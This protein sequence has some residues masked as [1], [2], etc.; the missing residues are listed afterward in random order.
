MAS[1]IVLKKSSVASKVPLAA[2]L[3]YGEVALNYQDG[4]LYYKKANNT[5]DAFTATLTSSAVTTAL[6][7]TPLSTGG[8]TITGDITATMN[9]AVHGFS[10]LP[11]GYV[12]SNPQNFRF[13]QDVLRYV[14][15]RVEAVIT[16]S[17]FTLG[18]V[19]VLFSQYASF[20]N[21]NGKADGSY[22]QIEGF[23][24]NNSANGYWW[25][26]IFTHAGSYSGANITME[27]K[28][29]GSAS[30]QTLYTGTFGSYKI[31]NIGSIGGSLTGVRW[32]FTGQ[33]TVNTYVR[34]LGV[35]GRNSDAY[36]WNIMKGGDTMFGDLTFA[37][38]Y[39]VRAPIFYDSA[40]PSFY[41]DPN[42]T[43]VL[44]G[45][46]LA[47]TATFN[48]SAVFNNT[49]THSGLTLTDGTNV[50][51]VKTITKSITL[52]TDWQDTGIKSTDLATGTYIVQL[53]ANDSGSGGTNNNEY[54]SGTMSWYSGD[55]NSALEMPTDE[56]VL[57][58]AGA[59]GEGALYLRT[60]RTPTADVNNL[61]L[62]IY[63]NT[64]NAS[65]ANYVFKFRRII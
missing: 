30:W 48:G 14:N 62:Q 40:N 58:R 43:S 59:S 34:Y 55:T 20:V 52:T 6:G 16:T 42:Q 22:I 65:A 18:E 11:S 56:I 26:Y 45:L 32:T 27:I 25:P 3:D 64:A 33:S 31:A 12:E 46:T 8:G 57:H 54:Y 41:L 47:N 9:Q 15:R 29:S 63:S 17:G 23:S 2:D 24:F 39:S 7:Y 60:Y 51:Q 49:V 5:I 50:D 4:K 28:T 53:I 44:S 37:P 10:T 61:K 1:K 13:D 21:L 38:G 36:N 35:I 19:D